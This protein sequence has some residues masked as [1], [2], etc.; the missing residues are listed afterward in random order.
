[1]ILIL[2]SMND[3]MWYV[4]RG[5]WCVV[6]GAWCVV[7]GAWCVV[8]G[9]WCVVRGAWCVVRAAR[10]AYV[11]RWYDTCNVKTASNSKIL[12]YLITTKKSKFREKTHAFLGQIG[13]NF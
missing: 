4:V 13:V 7:R 2:I 5:K 1:M 8:R 3:C 6:R 11:L 10:G 9:A 12:V